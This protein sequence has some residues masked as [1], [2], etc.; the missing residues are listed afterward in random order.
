MFGKNGAASSRER[1]AGENERCGPSVTGSKRWPRRRRSLTAPAP[2]HY[3]PFVRQAPGT[4]FVADLDAR[5]DLQLKAEY[6]YAA[7]EQI[8]GAAELIGR[9]AGLVWRSPD[10][11][12]E[13]LLP[14]ESDLTC[15]WRASSP[16]AGIA[17]LRSD[18]RL[19]SLSLLACGLAAEQDA[20]TL[21]AFQSHLLRELHDTGV[22]PS[23]DLL[24][25][26]ERPL[27]ATINFEPPAGPAYAQRAAALVD[28]CFA[29]A[30]F[31]YHGLA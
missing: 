29:A 16:S 23:F 3:K 31:R 25:L 20:L 18:G 27:V 11:F 6:R 9:L 15:R 14:G 8:P 30:Y 13:P 19:L 28:R 12:E 1:R 7:L 17:T 5:G 22:E 26:H 10:A 4:F 21:R 2:P 24:G